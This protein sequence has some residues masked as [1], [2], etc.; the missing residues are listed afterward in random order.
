MVKQS[1]PGS[2]R[3]EKRDLLN[4]YSVNSANMFIS[5]HHAT[6]VRKQQ[7]QTARAE[8]RILPGCIENKQSFTHLMSTNTIF[9]VKLAPVLGKILEDVGI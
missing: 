3:E 4:I 9:S 8:E 2:A 5:L 1:L 7:P 6:D